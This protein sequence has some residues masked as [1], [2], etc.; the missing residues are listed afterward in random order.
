[1]PPHS[2]DPEGSG[3]FCS[4]DEACGSEDTKEEDD[5]SSSCSDAGDAAVELQMSRSC[6]S[7]KR[8]VLFCL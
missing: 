2:P 5:G 8:A 4:R 6:L 1:M 3:S 7:V